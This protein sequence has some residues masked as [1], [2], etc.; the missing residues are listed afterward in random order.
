M[1]AGTGASRG[2]PVSEGNTPVVFHSRYLPQ[3]TV[4]ACS[5]VKPMVDCAHVSS[6]V[7][8]VLPMQEAEVINP[9]RASQTSVERDGQHMTRT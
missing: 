8:V 5:R 9:L 1:S 6:P 4:G 3:R 7:A 2:V